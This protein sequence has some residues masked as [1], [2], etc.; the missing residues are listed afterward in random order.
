MDLNSLN[1]AL[2][3]ILNTLPRTLAPYEAIKILRNFFSTIFKLK[4]KFFCQMKISRAE[5][6]V[7]TKKI[8]SKLCKV[9]TLR[10]K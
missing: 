9:E 10:Q 6:C 7:F 2:N 8:G 4:K 1:K 3:S 5:H